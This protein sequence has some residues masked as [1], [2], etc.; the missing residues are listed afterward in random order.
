MPRGETVTKAISRPL[1]VVRKTVEQRGWDRAALAVSAGGGRDAA[2][3]ADRQLPA[4]LRA[5]PRCA[6]RLPGQ[7]APPR[8]RTAG[9][10]NCNFYTTTALGLLFFDT[11]AL[12]LCVLQSMKRIVKRLQHSS[13]VSFDQTFLLLLLHAAREADR[14][15]GGSV[16][17]LPA[18]LFLR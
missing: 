11:T 17:C 6:Q 8:T 10:T 1:F 5:Q 12:G 16:A 2:E 4:H 3:R 15:V 18:P 7:P 14:R 9:V 13:C